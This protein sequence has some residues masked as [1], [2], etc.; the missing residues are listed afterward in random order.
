L[1]LYNRL[2]LIEY[3]PAAALNRT[4][5]LAKADGKPIAIPEA[6]KLKLEKNHLY[7]SLMGYLH[8]DMD[9]EKAIRHLKTALKLAKSKSDKATIQKS[10]FK[11]SS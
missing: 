9:N 7:H 10:I 2:L 5:A 11:I 8:T 4:Y 6:E 1:Q 3:S